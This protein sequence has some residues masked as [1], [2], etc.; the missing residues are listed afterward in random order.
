MPFPYPGE[1]KELNEFTRKEATGQFARLSDGM[2][3][4]Q[5][6]GD[7]TG[8]PVALVHGFSAPFFVFD[9]V[10]DLLTQHGFRVLRYD[11]FGRGFSDRPHLTYDIHL[12]VRQLRELLDALQLDSVD[13]LGYSMGGP[14]A[15]SFT[16][17][18]PDSVSRNMFIAPA[19]ARKVELSKLLEL[20]KLP[21]I[22]E[23]AL[24]LFGNASM[25]KGL[26]ADMYSPQMVEKFQ[27]QYVV[28]MRYKGFKHA[29]LSTMR[30]G[31]LDSFNETYRRVGELHKPILL[32]WGKQD[33]TVPFAHSAELLRLIPHAQL[34]SFE[35]C[36]HVPQYEKADEFN[37]CLLRFLN[38]T[39]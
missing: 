24:G 13:L 37:A 10:Y 17:L 16:A 15:A 21:V 11:L 18:H 8:K 23:L 25:V 35:P 9:P 31:M 27:K 39:T 4:Y 20:T 36:G 33:A 30:S 1:I 22:G 32:L 14:I 7:P 12:Y 26:A 2:T 29:I 3:H 5:L 6:G 38:T 34:C 28:Q 19:G